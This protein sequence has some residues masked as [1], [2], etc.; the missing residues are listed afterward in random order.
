M[1]E[2]HIERLGGVFEKLTTAGLRLK[3]SKCEFFK[4]KI[5]YLGHIVSRDG[6]EMEKKKVIAIQERPIPKTATEV[7]S[8]LGFRNYYHKFIPKYAPIA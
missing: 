1:P 3:L 6:I 7:C 8:F 5:A 4:P 2:E